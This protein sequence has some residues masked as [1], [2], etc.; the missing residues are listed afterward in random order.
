MLVW[1]SIDMIRHPGGLSEVIAAEN[2]DNTVLLGNSF[3][4]FCQHCYPAIHSENPK[5]D[6]P[7]FSERENLNQP[8][9]VPGKHTVEC[10]TDNCQGVC[11][12]KLGQSLCNLHGEAEH[13]NKKDSDLQSRNMEIDTL[14]NTE[15]EITG[16]IDSFLR[17][18]MELSHKTSLSDTNNTRLYTR[19]APEKEE[20]YLNV[21]TAQAQA[22]LCL[23]E[24]I[25]VLETLSPLPKTPANLKKFDFQ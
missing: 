12:R 16:H 13:F 25:Q 2:T 17:R 6:K 24:M 20:L 4:E 14:L 15:M 19:R 5:S 23:R 1:S 7:G 9:H 10:R 11:Q 21:S 22:E 3:W 8:S 18:E